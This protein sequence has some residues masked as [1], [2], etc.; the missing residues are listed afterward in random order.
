M[1]TE[2][3][4]KNS[5]QSAKQATNRAK[6]QIE[7]STIEPLRAYGALTTD[8]YEQL[9][10]TQFD[11]V[12]S[13]ADK[14]LAQSRAWLD[15]RDAESFQKVVE[16]QQQ[17]IR[18]MRERLKEDAIKISNLSQ[19]YLKESQQLAMERM[20]VG[21]KQLEENM[22]EGKEQIEDSMQQGKEQL[23][24]SMDQGKE[25][26]KDNMQHGKEQVKDNVQKGREQT[27]D[28]LQKGKEEVAST[29]QKS[30]QQTD[31]SNNSSS[32]PKK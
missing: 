7:S 3:P 23:K 11:A 24:A 27:K 25:Q 18:D 14:S 8:Y 19:E 17:A 28:N 4:K 9:F 6:E 15:V 20:Q 12:R 2:K 21:R 30:H 1:S 26:V 31:K 22:Q 13:F 29:Q 16:E 5:D 32:T 10:S